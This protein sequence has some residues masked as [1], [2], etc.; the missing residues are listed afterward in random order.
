VL[1][2]GAGMAGL[3]AAAR[4]RELG[5]SPVVLEKGVRPGGSMLLSSGVVWRYRSFK[6]FRAQCPGGDERLQRLVFDR[7]D[8]GLE[9]LESLG[10]PV[11]ERETGNPLTTGVRF[12]TAGLTEALV[13][14]AGEVRFEQPVTVTGTDTVTVTG[15]PLVLATGGFQGDPELVARYVKPAAPLRVRA[16]PWSSGDGL[17]LALA[18]GAALSEGLDEFYGRNMAD[19][20]FGEDEFVSLAQVFGRYARIFN[21]RG[22]EFFDHNAVSWSE[23]DLVQATAHQ[24][25]A[26]AWYVF[27][28]EALD[29]RVRYGTVRE[30]VT[31]TPTRVDPADLPFTP[32]PQAVVATRVAPAITHTIGGL[33]IDER[34]RVLDDQADPIASLYAAGVDAGGISAGGYASGLAAA[35]VLGLTAAETALS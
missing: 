13:R 21:D 24:P 20:D 30:L 25:G 9:W 26:R 17:K 4:A 14:D 33:R 29:E 35:L 11:L 23:L 12:D 31:Q 16:N 15:D 7:L 2:A 18:R 27:D 8:E 34:A 3:C 1:I 28:E 5:A 10:A 32:P 6:E 19:V 22:E